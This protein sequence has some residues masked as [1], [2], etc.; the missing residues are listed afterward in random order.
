M[1][2][3]LLTLSRFVVEMISCWDACGLVVKAGL[4]EA[5]QVSK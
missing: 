2:N 5:R 1:K 3:I 4:H